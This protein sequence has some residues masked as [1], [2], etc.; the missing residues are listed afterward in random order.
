MT[1]I[2]KI[3]KLSVSRSEYFRLSLVVLRTFSLNVNKNIQIKY[4]LIKVTSSYFKNVLLYPIADS[5]G[6]AV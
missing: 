4:P 6:C 5:G 1:Y 3:K 2:Y